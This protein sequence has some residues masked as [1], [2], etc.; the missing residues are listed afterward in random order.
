VADGYTPTLS[1]KLIDPKAGQATLV[2][3]RHD[4]DTRDP[5]LVL[6]GRV[7]DEQGHPVPDAAV[8]PL[9]YEKGDTGSFGGLKGFDPLALTDAKGEFRVGVPEK[10]LTLYVQVSARYLA[11]QNFAKLAVGDSWYAEGGTAALAQA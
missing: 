4:L 1:A 9:G 7:L 8:E 3:K 5:A 11:R 2:V 6:R 10:G